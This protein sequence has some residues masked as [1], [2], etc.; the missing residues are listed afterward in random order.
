MGQIEQDIRV[1]TDTLDP[2]PMPSVDLGAAAGLY[3]QAATQGNMLALH[4]FAHM[5]ARGYVYE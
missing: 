5:Q 3:L 4:R 2:P 1:V